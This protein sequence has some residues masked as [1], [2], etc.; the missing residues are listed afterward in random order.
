MSNILKIKSVTQLNTLFGKQETKHPLITIVDFSKIKDYKNFVGTSIFSELYAI[1]LKQQCDGTFNYGRNKFDFSEGSLVFV[2]PDH[3]VTIEDEI[4]SPETR[5]WGIF[6]HPDLLKESNL[7]STIK[8][9]SYFYYTITEALHISKEEKI[10]LNSI[11]EKLE[12]EI[13]NKNNK[14]RHSKT[15]ITSNI[16][17][18]LDYCSRYFDRQFKTRIA[19]SDGILSKF[20]SVLYK[21]Y[22]SELLISEGVPSVKYLAN[23]LSLSPNYLSDLL[24]KET[25]L[26]ALEHIHKLI[27][28]EAKTKLLI[29]KKSI[30]SIAYDL[31]FKY[32]QYFTRL[33]KKETGMTPRDFRSFK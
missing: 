15:I 23:E 29:S 2:A 5:D 13:S 20:E 21:Y 7:N 4:V 9:Y 31:G 27:I 26:G 6:F 28:K 19:K 14:D 16:E 17:L 18:L 10:S 25:G 32:P 11:V 8:Y 30:S 3:I 1:M 22:Q 12:K 24:K 33:F